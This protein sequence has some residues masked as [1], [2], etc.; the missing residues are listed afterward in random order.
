MSGGVRRITKVRTTCLKEFDAHWEC[1]ERNN[2]VR[3][4]Y[5]SRLPPPPLN[6]RPLPQEFYL[7]RKPE[8][9]F[10]SCVFENLVRRSSR[11]PSARR[12]HAVCFPPQ[13]LAKT[14]PGSPAGQA[15]IHEKKSPIYKA[16]QK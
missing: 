11:S 14:I 16:I 6:A 13:K 2:Q 4:P 10:N 8:R 9:V 3:R 12:A 15:P 1:L 5:P 7:C